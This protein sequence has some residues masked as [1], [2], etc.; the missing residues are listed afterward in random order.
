MS[1]LYIL[2]HA[3][4]SWSNALVD[5]HDRP[6]STRG[7]RACKTL[8]TQF[9]RASIL[10]ELVLC[11]T[12]SRARQTLET[13]LP[14]L[15]DPVVTYEQEL[16]HA[17]T[18]ELLTR[19]RSVDADSVLLVGH[20]PGL[21]ELVLL[22]ATPVPLRE[23]VEVKLPTGALATLEVDDW[24]SLGPG[25]ASLVALVTPRELGE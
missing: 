13:L 7:R 1:R 19:L 24:A 22:V 23:Q 4:S 3:K 15:G 18:D 9:V 10:P 5:D 2:R 17:G 20:N 25:T 6:L 21:Q 16:Y 12:A 14:V 11:S 8:R